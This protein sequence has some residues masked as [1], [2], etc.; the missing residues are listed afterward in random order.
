MRNTPTNGW[1][2]AYRQGSSPKPNPRSASNCCDEPSNA[3]I[4]RLPGWLRMNC[5]VILPLFG[6][7]W[8]SWTNAVSLR[9]N[10]PPPPSAANLMCTCLIGKVGVTAPL[11]CICATQ[12][13]ARS[14]FGS[15]LNRSRKKAGR[16]PS[17]GKAAKVRLS[18]TLPSCVSP[19]RWA[20]SPLP[21]SG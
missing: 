2:V 8:P 20:I 10:L 11:A 5:M 4:C 12:K 14:K 17:S 15:W 6:M 9:S 3:A 19:N 1:H 13:I 18:A 7:G 21:K 16:P